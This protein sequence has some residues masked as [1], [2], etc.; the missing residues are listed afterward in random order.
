MTRPKAHFSTEGKNSFFYIA[1]I[2]LYISREAK[3]AKEISVKTKKRSV[4]ASEAC[5][6]Q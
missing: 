6:K 4:K 2:K 5:H 3:R 1:T